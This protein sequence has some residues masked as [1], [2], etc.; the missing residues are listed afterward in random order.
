M[1]HHARRIPVFGYDGDFHSDWIRRW[2]EGRVESGSFWLWHRYWWERAQDP[3][4]DVLWL[5]FEDV[6]RA[7]LVEVEKIARFLRLDRV[8]GRSNRQFRALIA[9]AHESS[10]FGKMKA[11]YANT[12]FGT[13]HFRKGGIGDWRN[14]FTAEESARFDALHEMHFSE[15]PALMEK[16]YFG[17]D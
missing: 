4:Q 1:F 3:S 2:S 16:F 12:R 7:P 11:N 14:Y 8:P 9:R 6:K 15:Y 5:Q 17:E 13:G 10:S